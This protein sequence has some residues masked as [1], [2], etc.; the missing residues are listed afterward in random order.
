MTN[1]SRPGT[2][3]G[4][5]YSP[6]SDAKTPPTAPEKASLVEDFIEIFYAPSRVFARRAN[7]GFWTP[8]LV[9]AVISAIFT[10]ANRS[11]TSAIFDAEFSRGA[12]KAMAANPQITQ[13]MMNTQRGISE[14]IGNVVF[15]F[16]M[17]IIVFLVGAFI[18]LAAKFVS[19]KLSY[20]SAVL[21]ATLSQIPRLLQAVL[22]TVQALL[23]DTT[24]ITSQHSVG[25]SPAR[26]MDADTTQK[27]L[28]DFIGRFDLFTLWVTALIGIGIAVVAK[29]PRSKGYAAAAIVWG[30]ATLMTVVSVLW[31]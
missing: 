23:M 28:L 16:A 29:I 22:T 5:P 1:P 13:E 6:A 24:T 31:S 27:Q 8:L 10:F 14:A 7:S 12:A 9:I 15:Y 3:H 4:A 2:D 18:W 21:I 25:F 19:A 26:F 17:P 30:I 11:V 20:Q